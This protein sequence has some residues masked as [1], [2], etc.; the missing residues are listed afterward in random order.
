MG[1]VSLVDLGLCFIKRSETF[2]MFGVAASTLRLIS[3]LLLAPDSETR[4]L[5]DIVK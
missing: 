2:F 3:A 1:D 4:E 5:E